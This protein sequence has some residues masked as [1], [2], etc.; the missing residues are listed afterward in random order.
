MLPASKGLD[1]IHLEVH[2]QGSNKS[3]IHPKRNHTFSVHF[4]DL[5]EI[6]FLFPF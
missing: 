5:N 6:E 4:C 2:I 1:T 3:S